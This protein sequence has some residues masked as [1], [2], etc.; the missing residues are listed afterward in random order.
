MDLNGSTINSTPKQRKKPEP[1]SIVW[2]LF[3]LKSD[4]FAYCNF[5]EC[6]NKYDMRKIRNTSACLDHLRRQHP[7]SLDLSQIC[8]KK[9]SGQKNSANHHKSP[10][11][12]AKTNSTTQKIAI[13]KKAIVRRFKNYNFKLSRDICTLVARDRFNFLSISKSDFIQRQ[14]ES[15]YE[16]RLVSAKSVRNHF[17]IFADH[18]KM[19]QKEYIAK[20]KNCSKKCQVIFDETASTSQLK[21]IGI[22]C[23]FE[24]TRYCNLGIIQ[25]TER[26]TA[27]KIIKA[28]KA[29]LAFYGIDLSKDVITNNTDSSPTLKKVQHLLE[30][31][32]NQTCLESMLEGTLNDVIYACKETSLRTLQSFNNNNNAEDED[33]SDEEMSSDDE[34]ED[35]DTCICDTLHNFLES[36]TE[37]TESDSFIASKIDPPEARDTDYEHDFEIYLT[38]LNYRPPFEETFSEDY[39]E[40]IELVRKIVKV[41]DKRNNADLLKQVAGIA[42][43]SDTRRSIWSLFEMLKLF[44]SKLEEIQK[45]LLDLGYEGLSNAINKRVLDSLVDALESFYI[46]RKDMN[47]DNCDFESA[48]DR[49]NWLEFDLKEKSSQSN[50]HWKLYYALRER[51]EKSFRDSMHERIYFTLTDSSYNDLNVDQVIDAIFKRF[52]YFRRPDANNVRLNGHADDES[53]R[54]EKEASYRNFLQQNRRPNQPLGR[55]INYLKANI[56]DDIFRFKRDG[57]LTPELQ[58]VLNNIFDIIPTSVTVDRPLINASFPIAKFRN[59]LQALTLNNIL[60][61]RTYLSQETKFIDL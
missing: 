56:R 24:R 11:S 8:Q 53:E 4:G 45:C 7:Q 28:I 21:L 10:S 9:S 12:L 17:N 42:M 36:D 2:R 3:T 35:A 20:M 47:N 37:D 44:T 52:N 14:F 13:Q 6:P 29:K 51:R 31:T 55:P 59:K 57:I 16:N 19:R 60:I 26:S 5:P 46:V 30:P 40:Q 58:I 22:Y 38:S 27:Y 1:K 15:I 18:V 49:M 50:V 39:R 43:K 54:S 48:F 33:V 23:V 61:L 41:F 25:M 34:N 32:F